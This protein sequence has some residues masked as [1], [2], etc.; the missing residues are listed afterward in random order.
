LFSWLGSGEAVEQVDSAP[1]SSGPFEMLSEQI[2]ME[3]FLATMASGSR[4]QVQKRFDA[5]QALRERRKRELMSQF[6]QFK[7]LSPED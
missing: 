4:A 3:S 6:D 2:T 1:T 5:W 7:Q